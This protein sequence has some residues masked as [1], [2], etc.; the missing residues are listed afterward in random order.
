VIVI[1]TERLRI[2]SDASIINNTLVFPQAEREEINLLD[3][4]QNR[5]EMN[6]FAIRLKNDNTQLVGQ[7]GFKNERYE[8]ELSYHTNEPYRRKH[9][10][11]EAMEAFIPWFFQNTSATVI[12]VIIA[13]GNVASE[14]LAKKV[15]FIRTGKC[16]GGSPLFL[17]SR[18]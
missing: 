11:Q 18:P 15:G 10:M 9:Y 14:N 4:K 5:P 13:E 7:F 12:H 8:N 6:A 1:E 17:I 16:S 2:Y 3:L